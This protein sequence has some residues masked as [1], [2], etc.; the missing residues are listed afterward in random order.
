MPATWP[1]FARPARFMA[2]V[3]V[4]ASLE[5]AFA[6]DDPNAIQE[7]VVTARKREEPAFSVP[8]A[9]TAYSG[10]ELHS[11][12]VNDINDLQALS[13]SLFVNTTSGAVSDTTIRMRG[14]GTTGNNA[15]LE[16]AVGVFIDGVYRNRSGLGLA[17]LID[18]D[19]VEV[20]RGPQSTVFGKNTSAGAV[21]IITHKPTEK[22]ESFVEATGGNLSARKVDGWTNIP[23]VSNVLALR[24]SGGYFKRDGFVEVLGRDAT[25]NGKD[26]YFF[27]GEA[28]YT[29]KP[30]IEFR[31]IADYSHKDERTGTAVRTLAGPTQPA[32]DII[33]ALSGRP[34]VDPPRPDDRV[35]ALDGPLFE[36][37][38]DEWGFSGELNVALS[39]NVK[40]TNILAW[41]DFRSWDTADVDYTAVGILNQIRTTTD[42]TLSEELR[43]AGTTPVGSTVLKSIDWMAG[44]YYTHEDIDFGYNLLNGTDAG[45]YFCAIQPAFCGIAATFVPG[46]GSLGAFATQA[47]SYSVFGQ[48]GLNLTDKLAL[49]GGVRYSFDKKDGFGR[50]TETSPS[51]AFYRGWLGGTPAYQARLSDDAWSGSGQIRYNWTDALMTY[52]GYAH[53]YKAGGINLDRSAAGISGIDPAPLNPAFGAE[54][55]DNYEAG[56]RS[57]LWNGRAQLSLTGFHTRFDNLQVLVFDGLA[58]AVVN[59]K[60]AQTH[61]VELEGALV[62]L[63]GLT[64]KGGLTFAET[65]Y[66]DGVTLPLRDPVTGAFSTPAQLGGKHLTNAPVWSMTGSALY[67]F[68]IVADQA[69]GFIGADI[70]YGSSRNTASEQTP[71]EKQKGYYLIN[72]HLGVKL[73]GGRW[74][75]SLW[76]KNCTDKTYFTTIFASVAQPGS[77]DGFIADG[78][79]W[80]GTVSAK[81]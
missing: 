32:I 28:L 6:Q 14:V 64:F 75:L 18:I 61:G 29:P 20:L 65:R 81:F 42:Q 78:R 7:I 72:S 66:D 46:T 8:V 16:G 50:M 52:L 53:G 49:T 80:G 33:S 44:L 25:I 35:N 47:R 74:T 69:A 63:T 19:R 56:I 79:E 70:Y 39:D 30:G 62:P 4:A 26:R 13:P 57:K 23:V 41:R 34:F 40:L 73:A 55:S 59:V 27:R 11:D 21:S 15:G 68:P 48:L 22:Y 9:V 54:T 31:F 1:I 10:S 45:T 71:Q 51:L 2:L 76:C 36:S 24:L 60:G 38:H 17:D 3:F 12:G 37:R 67:E 5:P 58:F 77:F 43:L